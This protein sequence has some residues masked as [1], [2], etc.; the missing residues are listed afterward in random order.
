MVV[1]RCVEHAITPEADSSRK[2]RTGE[3]VVEGGREGGEE[4]RRGQ[5][6]KKVMKMLTPKKRLN[7][8]ILYSQCS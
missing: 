4:P 7:S 3:G 8:S 1:V 5:D 6:E 2:E